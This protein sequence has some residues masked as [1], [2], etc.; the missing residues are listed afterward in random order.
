SGYS[1]LEKVSSSNTYTEAAQ[2]YQAA[3][4]R[5]P[6]RADLYELAGHAYYHAQDYVN[7]EAAYQKAFQ[8]GALSPEGWVAWGDVNYLNQNPERA[9]EIWE[10]AFEQK[11]PSEQLYSR[12]A[13]TY[14]ETGDYSNAADALQ[15]YV[16]VYS[17]DAAAHYRLGLLLTL[18]D[19]NTALSELITAS[20][21]DPQLDPAVQ[22][23][24]TALNLAL[25]NDSPS[26]RFV[27]I[28]RGLGVLEEWQLAHVA[29]TEAVEADGKNA[30]AWAW[31]EESNQ[32]IGQKES[33]G[34]DRAL[35]LS[36]NSSV[37]RGLRGLHF[38]RSGNFRQALEEFKHAARLEPDNPAWQVS[39]GEA[40]AK[41][42][43]L[44]LALEAY[45]QATTLAPDDP[46]YWRLLAIFCAQN[47][48][49]IKDVGIPA[50]QR[51]LIMLK[52]DSS[53]EDLLGWLHL[54]DSRY[55]ES[56]R[57]LTRALELDPQNAAA[58][59]HLA[60]LYLQKGDRIAAYD[61]LI[62][63][64]ELGNTEAEALLKQYFP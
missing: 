58:H 59:L 2:H 27:I 13:Q 24:R 25:I 3:A 22:T 43:D 21:L 32:H 36:P 55:E 8:R 44:I 30:E 17:E 60:M 23:L 38:Q 1:E 50:A 54:L 42:G 47:G 7:A 51:F 39:I 5:I 14:Q 10:Q 4:Q 18:S 31:L 56:E 6:W 46:N 48:V 20:Q 15:R 45:Q 12:L 28:G 41:L 64:R 63:A 37:I 62:F 9:A 16:S 26:E 61:Q 52:D 53:A 33:D 35:R 40:Y 34:L 19:Q 29:F 57:H 11:D 49:H